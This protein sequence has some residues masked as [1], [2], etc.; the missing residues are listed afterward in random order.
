[1]LIVCWNF[2]CGGCLA[3]L[4]L[5]LIVDC[6]IVGVYLCFCCLLFVGFC[7]W[8]VCV[9]WLCVYLVSFLLFYY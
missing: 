1:M 6:C 4:V 7:A 5:C 9:G 3:L 2:S 8:L